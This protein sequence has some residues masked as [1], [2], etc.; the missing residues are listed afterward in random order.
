M[1]E[2]VWKRYGVLT[3]M[4]LTFLGISGILTGRVEGVVGRYWGV[5]WQV[6]VDSRGGNGD[7]DVDV[8]SN[9][10]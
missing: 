1:V 5:G 9:V 10:Y 7:S 6:E 8:T 2:R 4:S 3:E